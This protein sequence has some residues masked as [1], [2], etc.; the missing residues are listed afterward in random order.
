LVLV[1]ASVE[2][3]KLLEAANFLT[4]LAMVRVPRPETQRVQPWSQDHSGSP[5]GKTAHLFQIS[6]AA[7]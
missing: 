1:G 3:E 7:K 2:T 4:A 5:Q 6:A